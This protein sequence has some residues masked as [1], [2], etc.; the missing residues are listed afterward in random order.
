MSLRVLTDPLTLRAVGREDIYPKKYFEGREPW[1][2]NNLAQLRDRWPANVTVV[3]L[4]TAG[5]TF[6]DKVSNTLAGRA[7]R[8]VIELGEEVYHLNSFRLA[9]SSGDPLYA[10]GFWFGEKLRGFVGQGADKTIIQ[11]DANSMTQAQLNA[12]ALKTQ[13]SF[14]PLQ[15]GFA[16]LDGAAGSPVIL[17]GITFRAADQQMLTSK[18][19]D[20]NITVPQPAPH[21]GV[22]IYSGGDSIVT[23]CRFQAAGRAAYSQPPYE[24]ANLNSQYGNHTWANC[25]FDGRRAPEIDP[26]QPR[27]V[28][29]VML[30]NESSHQMI[31]CWQHHS[32]VSRY[33]VNDEN[34]NTSGPY[35]VDGCQSEYI[36][37]TQNM[38]PDLNE[39]NSLRGWVTC[40][41]YGWESCSSLI[42]I[43]RSVIR[44]TFKAPAGG[45][46]AVPTHFRLTSVGGRNPQGGRLVATDNTYLTP[47]FPWLNG[48]CTIRIQVNSYWWSDGLSNTINITQKGQRLLPWEHTG[49]WPPTKQQLEAAGI[50]P[51]THYIMRRN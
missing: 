28:G 14:S 12:I 38:D 41:D 42:T 46:G 44:Q 43:R 50:T 32:N 35:T 51:D 1:R 45:F 37:D 8:V 6:Y 47:A 29:V 26:K 5:A 31:D 18:A 2:I 34:R 23:Y 13:A 40:S 33:A 4:S 22:V 17:S 7:D 25:E 11:M 15:L 19:P 48:F 20:V 10:F 9:G 27:R 36:S 49:A 3:P 39:G 16:R 24:M 30:N 21:Q